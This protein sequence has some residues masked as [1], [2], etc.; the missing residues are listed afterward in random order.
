MMTRRLTL[1]GLTYTV[2]VAFVA[3]AGAFRV[4]TC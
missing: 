4:A 1:R 3:A 2:L